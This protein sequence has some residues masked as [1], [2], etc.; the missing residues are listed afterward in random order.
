MKFKTWPKA[1]TKTIR[2]D[3]AN[4]MR[5]PPVTEPVMPGI[6]HCPKC[7]AN[8]Y[9]P[10]TETEDYN[11]AYCLGCGRDLRLPFTRWEK[12]KHTLRWFGD[13]RAMARWTIGYLVNSDGK[14]SKGVKE[15]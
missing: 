9:F 6:I 14:E 1:K 7:N 13:K 2:Y 11:G 15:K 3:R 10:D 5:I 8:V 12:I 4:G